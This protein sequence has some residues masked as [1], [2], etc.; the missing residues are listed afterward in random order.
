M[1][2]GGAEAEIAGTQ[3]V[4]GTSGVGFC[5]PAGDAEEKQ[6]KGKESRGREVGDGGEG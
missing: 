4:V 6:G 1:F 3:L 5:G 2:G